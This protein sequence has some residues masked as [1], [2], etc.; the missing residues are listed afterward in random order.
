MDPTLIACFCE[1]QVSFGMLAQATGNF[2]HVLAL[3]G[4][5]EI[6]L[7]FFQPQH[8][9]YYS[10]N[11]ESR[12]RFLRGEP[13]AVGNFFQAVADK[14]HVPFREGGKVPVEE[15]LLPLFES[16]L[17][18]SQRKLGQLTGGTHTVVFPNLRLIFSDGIDSDS[19]K[20]I[21]QVATK[22]GLKIQ[23]TISLSDALSQLTLRN[24]VDT[25]PIRNALYVMAEA[26]GLVL[27][28]RQFY[29][30]GNTVLG[31]KRIERAG[32]GLMVEALAETLV[33]TAISRYHSPLGRHPERIAQE[34]K[35]Y[36]G[37]AAE[38]LPQFRHQD[39]LEL[40]VNLS[41]NGGGVVEILKADLDAR[42]RQATE[43]IPHLVAEFL[44]IHQL[45]PREI[46]QVFLFGD[47]FSHRNFQ[48]I[49]FQQ[50]VSGSV[51][52]M[53]GDEKSAALDATENEQSGIENRFQDVGAEINL[54]ELEES[55]IV[56]L[57][58][59]GKNGEHERFHQTIRALGRER[60]EVL[61]GSHGLLPKDTVLVQPNAQVG[62]PLRM[63]LISCRFCD[64]YCT[65]RNLTEW[66]APFMTQPITKI[67]LAPSPSIPL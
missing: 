66:P 10:F 51:K 15:L 19:R 30:G 24:F 4:W 60:F 44:R 36:H 14:V 2:V 7:Y 35:H 67:L 27:V 38:N 50:F 22:A 47:L 58:V 17:E 20:R 5:K 45:L 55:S 16:I 34:I 31:M 25:Q 62:N 21:A 59:R 64:G 1:D 39:R 18:E 26:D 9:P 6:P 52:L 11:A 23:T 46:I 33:K 43:R 57:F 54:H 12:G 41:D 56:R 65:C 3:R 40:Q 63:K 61:H 29:Q 32:M 13:Y 37:M 48:Q 49:F 8:S 28:L 53:H 42:I